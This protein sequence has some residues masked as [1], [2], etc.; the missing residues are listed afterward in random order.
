MSPYLPI[1]ITVLVLTWLSALM[2]AAALLAGSVVAIFWYGFAVLIFGV[3]F[4]VCFDRSM[5]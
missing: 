4:K 3:A 5:E 2:L 1:G